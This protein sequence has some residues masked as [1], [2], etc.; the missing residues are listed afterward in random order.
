L[1]RFSEGTFC[2]LLSG[3]DKAAFFVVLELQNCIIVVL[4][5][6]NVLG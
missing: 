1:R 2:G 5:D 3:F 4:S 6:K